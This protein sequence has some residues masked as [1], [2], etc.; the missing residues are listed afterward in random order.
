MRSTSM[1]HYRTMAASPRRIPLNE[2]NFARN[3]VPG[4]VGPD[5]PQGRL[6]GRVRLDRADRQVRIRLSTRTSTS[7]PCSTSC[8]PASRP[9]PSTPTTSQP[10]RGSSSATTTTHTETGSAALTG[11][12]TTCSVRSPRRPSSPAA[13][14]AAIL[15]RLKPV[16]VCEVQ[17]EP[18]AVHHRGSSAHQRAEGDRDRRAPDLRHARLTATTPRSS[19]RTRPSRTSRRPAAKLTKHIYDYVVT[20]SKVERN[21]VDPTRHQQRGRCLRQAAAGI[22]HPDPGRRL[23]PGLG[24]RL[25]GGQGQARLLRRR[26]QGLAVLTAAQRCRADQDRVRPQVLRVAQRQVRQERQV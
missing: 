19:P 11:C 17:A 10:A 26:D 3:G 25:R 4:T 9:P 5:Q 16:D 14:P 13:P 2:E 7:R 24:H 23:Q 22:L 18:R 20:D 8:R 12:S 6:P 21:F 15:G 1:S